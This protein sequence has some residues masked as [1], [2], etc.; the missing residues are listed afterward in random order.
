M[1]ASRKKIAAVASATRPRGTRHPAVL[2][3]KVLCLWEKS[4][5][6]TLHTM[7]R[8]DYRPF[9]I[10]VKRRMRTMLNPERSL[11]SG[12]AIG[13]LWHDKLDSES[14]ARKNEGPLSAVDR[15]CSADSQAADFVLLVT[16]VESPYVIVVVEW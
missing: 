7:V 15:T 3:L 14:R 13:T 9:L 5:K 12:S 2:G 16:N 6:A 8:R 10:V 4:G 1:S 11:S